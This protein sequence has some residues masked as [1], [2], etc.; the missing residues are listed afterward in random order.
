[1]MRHLDAI[2]VGFEHGRMQPDNLCHLGCRD[3][4]AFPPERIAYAVREKQPVLLV[5]TDD[6]SG[7]ESSIP[8]A[9]D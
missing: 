6:I 1:M 5:M 7:S 3:V 9:K 4:L 2:H 8:F